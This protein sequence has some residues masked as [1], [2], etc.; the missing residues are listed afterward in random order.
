M[1]QEQFREQGSDIV[2]SQ[3]SNED[4]SLY[5]AIDQFSEMERERAVTKG[6]EMMRSVFRDAGIGERYGV[7]ASTAIYLQGRMRGF[8]EKEGPEYKIF[9]GIPSDFDA[10]VS[11]Q[12]DLMRVRDTLEH[13]PGH[14]FENNGQFKVFAAAD[15]KL[16]AGS[17]DVEIV[18]D[19]GKPIRVP[20]PFEIFADS[21]LFEEETFNRD[22]E[23]VAGLRTLTL[24]ALKKQ[25][26]KIREFDMRVEREAKKVIDFLCDEDVRSAL[27]EYAP[28][29][30]SGRPHNDEYDGELRHIREWLELTSL[31]LQHFYETKDEFDESFDAEEKR[32]LEQRM[33]RILSGFSAKTAQREEKI[34]SLHRM[35]SGETSDR[36]REKQK[37]RKLR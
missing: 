20:Y 15:A 23:S 6:I 19:R 3:E 22:T 29:L 7:F 36:G 10:A 28:S 16:L 24:E 9:H 32:H 5:D 35:L 14:A 31:D 4:F 21:F 1:N 17:F 25:Y 26:E 34:I 11:S 13:I 8:R 12:A 27:G 30:Q 33:I 2:A 18:S 37:G